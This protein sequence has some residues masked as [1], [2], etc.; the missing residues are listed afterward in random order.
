VTA[1][2]RATRSTILEELGK[3]GGS[4]DCSGSPQSGHVLRGG[5]MFEGMYLCTYEL[6]SSIPRSTA[7][8]R[9]RRR[10]WRGRDDEDVSKSRLVRDGDRQDAP[11]FGLS[12][13]D[14][15]TIERLALE[16]EAKLGR[17]SIAASRTSRMSSVSQTTSACF[18][19]PVKADR[20]GNFQAPKKGVAKYSGAVDHQ[21]RR[22]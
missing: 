7:A 19:K 18:G 3:L 10:S 20:S 17:T 6:F 21:L 12:E 8:R 22:R 14:I 9:S 4:L 13:K 1:T 11:E 5:R 16:P 2:C 15:L